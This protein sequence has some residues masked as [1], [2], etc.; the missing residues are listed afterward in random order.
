VRPPK[1]PPSCGSIVTPRWTF[2]AG[3]LWVTSVPR[4]VTRPSHAGTTPAS[5]FKSVDFPDPF[6]P[7]MQ[8]TPSRLSIEIPS[9]TRWFP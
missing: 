2:S 8:V 7:K 3:L 5:V 1:I 4:W 6:G 9:T